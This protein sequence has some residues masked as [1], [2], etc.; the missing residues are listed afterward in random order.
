M[1]QNYEGDGDDPQRNSEILP[2]DQ[3]VNPIPDIIV[4]KRD[5]ELDEFVVIACDGIF[6]VQTNHECISLTAE[7]FQEGE[8]DMGLVC[9]EVGGIVLLSFAIAVNLL[10]AIVVAAEL[11]DSMHFTLYCCYTPIT[12]IKPLT[13]CY[14]HDHLFVILDS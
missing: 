1:E 5:R 10:A 4:Q 12:N 13:D 9:E 11:I 3:K 14:D 2:D 7:I 8:D 6:D